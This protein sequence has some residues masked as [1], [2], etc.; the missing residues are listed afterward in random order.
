MTM[1]SP[2]CQ[3]SRQETLAR[4]QP[5][6]EHPIPGDPGDLSGIRKDCT[7]MSASSGAVVHQEASHLLSS[8]QVP[9]WMR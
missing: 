5:A 4:P 2:H 9:A 7:M 1:M 6:A 8:T 3:S